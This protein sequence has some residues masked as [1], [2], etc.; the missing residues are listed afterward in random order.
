[1]LIARAAAA[2]DVSGTPL[3]NMLTRVV[4]VAFFV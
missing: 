4:F 2:E 1:M 3:R